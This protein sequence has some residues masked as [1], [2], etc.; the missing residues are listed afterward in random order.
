MKDWLG[1]TVC[2]I[3]LG[4]SGRAAAELLL[5]QGAAVTAID[6]ADTPELRKLAQPLQQRGAKCHWGNNGEPAALFDLGVVSPGVPLDHPRVVNLRERGIPVWSELELG[7]RESDCLAIGITGT[8]GKTTTTELVT[9]ILNDNQRR[10]IAAGNIGTPLCAV[11][12][13]TRELDVL[14]L[15]VSS[16]QLETIDAFRPNI[17]V[18]LNLA[19]D[20]LDRHGSMENYIRA[21]ARLFENQEPFDRAII[22][23]DAWRELKRLGIDVPSKVITFS[24]TDDAADLHLDRSL[25]ISRVP[26]WTGPILDLDECQLGGLH[27]AEN[28][29][30]ALLVGRA[31]K[32]TVEDMVPALRDFKAGPHRCEL[33]AAQCGVKFFNDSKATN[34]HALCSALRSMPAAGE[35]KNIWL[36]AG[37]QDKSLDFHAA[38]PD[39]NQRVKG[40]FLLG[41]TREQ[42][43]AAWSLFAPCNLVDNLIEAVAEA[44]RNAVPG[45]VVLLSPACASFDMFG[46]YQ[47][48]GE[49]F[50]DA[51]VEWLAING[52]GD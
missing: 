31:M 42:L 26:G 39:V 43:R 36:I 11:A 48:R 28:L 5:D 49:S 46:S 22:Q 34:V 6:D 14:T 12:G 37:G 9:A 38:G 52:H 3:G 47:H 8:N 35:S 15:E 33:I 23:R 25:L 32:L 21:K 29:L 2:V 30:A 1:K 45:D 40:A 50:R 4:R 17:A 19:P 7:W 27:N 44:G 24:A 20:H 10:T 16:F 13:R 41:E 18:L 51:V